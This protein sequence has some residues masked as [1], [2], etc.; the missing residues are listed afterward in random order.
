MTE[1]E[2][3]GIRTVEP[4]GTGESER[5]T[6][7]RSLYATHVRRA[8]PTSVARQQAWLQAKSKREMQ[9]M[10]QQYKSKQEQAQAQA[11]ANAHQAAIAAQRRDLLLKLVRT[12][13][14]K[15]AAA[16][17][18]KKQ[19]AQVKALLPLIKQKLKIKKLLTKLQIAGA[20]KHGSLE[21]KKMKA[22]EL[23]LEADKLRSEASIVKSIRDQKNPRHSSGTGATISLV[24]P[25]TMAS[26]DHGE[27][28]PP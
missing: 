18:K 26:S 1:S 12:L 6:I 17:A 24:L 21:A 14:L 25:G 19:L 3:G 22:D 10:V 4:K 20:I 23:A 5:G 15:R 2:E 27:G 7:A 8:A 13:N 16:E 11:Q 9:V 28:G